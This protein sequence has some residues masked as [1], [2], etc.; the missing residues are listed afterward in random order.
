MKASVAEDESA[1][2]VER[3]AR[4]Q[5]IKMLQLVDER[6]KEEEVVKGEDAK[7]M[8]EGREMGAEEEEEGTETEERIRLLLNLIDQVLKTRYLEIIDHSWELISG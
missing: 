3:E 7:K 4:M 5:M 8:K 1:K 2:K 6:N